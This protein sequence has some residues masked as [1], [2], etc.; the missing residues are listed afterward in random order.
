M[1][2]ATKNN[3]LYVKMKITVPH[4]THLTIL[5]HIDL[6]VLVFSSSQSLIYIIILRGGG[7]L[8]DVITIGYII[9]V[10]MNWRFQKEGPQRRR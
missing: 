1:S 8:N 7:G 9:I 10:T 2:K 6:Y 4:R 3:K 5:K